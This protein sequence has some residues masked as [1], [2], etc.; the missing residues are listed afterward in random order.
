MAAATDNMANAET[1]AVSL[2]ELLESSESSDSDFQE[3]IVKYIIKKRN[4]PKIRSFIND[5]VGTC[6]DLE[7]RIYFQCIFYLYNSGVFLL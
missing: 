5:V 7:V 4:I 2:L 1:I 3:E 6:D